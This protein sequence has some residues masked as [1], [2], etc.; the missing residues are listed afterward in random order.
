M[1]RRTKDGMKL[2]RH[3][4]QSPAVTSADVQKVLDCTPKTANA[5]IEIFTDRGLLR[6]LDA[7]QRNRIFLFD[8]YLNLFRTPS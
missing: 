2:L 7:R 1:G 8:E 5:M 4:F 6:P 3:L